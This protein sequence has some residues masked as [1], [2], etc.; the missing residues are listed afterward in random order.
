MPEKGKNILLRLHQIGGC[1][2][3]DKYSKGWDDA[4]TEAIR[5]VEEEMGISIVE[6]LD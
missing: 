1:D 3:T 6:V 5:I 4:I 2:A